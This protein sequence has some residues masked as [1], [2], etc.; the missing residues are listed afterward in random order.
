MTFGSGADAVKYPDR[1][2]IGGAWVNPSTDSKFSVISPSTEELYLQVAEAQAE[3]VNRAVA[4][5]R[6]A[7]DHGPWPKMSHAERARYLS[8]AAAVLERRAPEASRIWTGQMGILLKHAQNMVSALPGAYEYHAGLA[9]T[10][11]FIEAHQ[12]KDPDRKAFIVREPT[13]VAALIVPWNSAIHQIVYKSAPALLA[14]CTVILKSSPESPVDGYLIS[15]IMEEIGLPPGVFNMITAEREVSELLVRHPGV[16]KVSFT[17]STAAGKKV[18]SI[19][20]ERVARCTLELGGK[21]AAVVLDDY[22]VQL[23]A[24]TIAASS[25]FITNQVCSAL[26]RVVVTRKR[27][28]QMV[29]A[30]SGAFRRIRVGDPFAAETDIGPLAMARQRDRVEEYIAR[31]V[32]DGALLAAGGGRPRDINRGFYIEPT[33]FGNVERNSVI[34]QEE[35]FGPVVTI[36]P[37]DDEND[38]VDIANGTVYGLN[39]SVFT[40]DID[41]AFEVAKTLRAGTVGHNSFQTDFQVGFGGYKESGIGREGGADGLRPYLEAKTVVLDSVPPAMSNLRVKPAEC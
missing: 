28:D 2:F 3:D 23:V 13:G 14:G 39:A 1:L 34:A 35:I 18:A 22:D 20:G 16:D 36:V 19:C 7:F 40:N 38:A 30:L 4:A 37:A 9:E 26:S 5:A 27:H 10:F 33:V 32:A 24:D 6:K 29:E 11:P 17:G 12:G 31:G 21:S 41:R 25:C 8:A 15:E